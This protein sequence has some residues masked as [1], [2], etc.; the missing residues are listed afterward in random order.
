L[1]SFLKASTRFSS[2]ERSASSLTE[3]SVALEMVLI[4]ES[5]SA[6]RVLFSAT[7]LSVW[8]SFLSSSAS[9]ALN[10][11]SLASYA[12]AASA[13]ARISAWRSPILSPASLSCSSR[14]TLAAARRSVS[15]TPF[16]DSLRL[17]S[18]R[19]PSPSISLAAPSS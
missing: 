15:L 16:R 13:A 12:S 8:S 2:A 9:R 7:P 18:S 10:P 3:R 4:F 5:S 14:S 19:S 1:S 6:R 17:F 11:S